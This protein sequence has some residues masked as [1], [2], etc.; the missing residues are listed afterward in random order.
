MP[1]LRRIKGPRLR[2]GSAS[3]ARHAW[4]AARLHP[5][6]IQSR[7]EISRGANG[8]HVSSFP[9]DSLSPSTPKASRKV[10]SRST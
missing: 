6:G 5:S 3:L 8:C 4:P 9:R 7:L 1:E 10:E 2:T